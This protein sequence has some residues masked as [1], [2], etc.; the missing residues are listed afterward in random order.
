LRLEIGDED[1]FETLRAYYAT[2]EDSI[3]TTEDFIAVAEGVSGTD[4]SD[5]FDKWLY[6]ESIPD[7]PSTAS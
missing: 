1:F 6:S 2:Y 4:L 7:L 5:L 3:A